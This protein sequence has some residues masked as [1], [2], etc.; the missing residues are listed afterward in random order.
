MMKKTIFPLLLAVCMIFSLAACGGN[1]GANSSTASGTESNSSAGDASKS[2]TDVL[3]MGTN[4]EFPPYEFY[5]DDKVVGID[6]EIAA[7]I[8]EKLGMTLEIEDMDFGSV[9]AAVESGTIDIGMAGMTVTED[10]EK[11]VN[12]TTS[13]A[14]GIQVIIVKDGSEIQSVDDLFAEGAYTTIGVQSNT[15][16]DIYST[17]DVE[18]K[19]LGEIMRYKRGADAINALQT[20]K[21]DCVIID[22]EPANEFVNANDGLKILD[23]EYAVEEYAIAIAK[24]NTDLLDKVNKALEELIADGTA[25]KI[26][27]K[28]INEE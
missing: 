23:T 13:Y 28:Y 24:D 4:A 9:V 26:I 12:F 16:G 5:E 8:A 2:G 19:G 20:D 25:Q 14:T 22:S 10:R 1:G 3:V 21:V 7:A 15:T 17:S 27:D 11:S 18:D 6:A